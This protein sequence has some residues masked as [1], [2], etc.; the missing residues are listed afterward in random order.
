MVSELK[1]YFK[2]LPSL[3]FGGIISGCIKFTWAFRLDAVEKCLL[4]GT[5]KVNPMWLVVWFCR[6]FL[7]EKLFSQYWQGNPLNVGGFQP[8]RISSYGPD[9]FARKNDG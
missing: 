7:L 3:T 9:I 6:D 5:H 1:L 8:P 4:H 2:K